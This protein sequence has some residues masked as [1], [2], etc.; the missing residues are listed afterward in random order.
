MKAILNQIR[1]AHK[2]TDEVIKEFVEGTESPIQKAVNLKALEKFVKA[3]KP[4]I[5]ESV[6]K[7]L[8]EENNIQFGGMKVYKTTSA[9]KL[10]YD[11][12]ED[13]A[14]LQKAKEEIERKQKAI[15]DNMKL[16]YQKGISIINEET[17]EVYEPARY[18]SGGQETF[19]VK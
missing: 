2:I 3:V 6:Q 18:K 9:T 12:N 10:S 16:A 8:D 14:N 15:E 11:H 1:N 7:E 19:A 4:L 13:W 17:G 5:S